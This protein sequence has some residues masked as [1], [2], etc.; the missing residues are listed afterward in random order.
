MLLGLAYRLERGC[1]PPNQICG[2]VE[3]ETS[4]R[5]ALSIRE[6]SGSHV[7]STCNQ[8]TLEHQRANSGLRSRELTDDIVHHGDL[9]L[10]IF[11]AVAVA[12]VDHQDFG[13]S[14]AI[15]QTERVPHGA[16]PEVGS[17]FSPASQHQVGV[18]IS[19]SFQN[20]GPPFLRQ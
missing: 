9:P 12:A 15:E 11:F 3:S 13:E 7:L 10:R 2:V 14:R 8:V 5:D 6:W 18:G 17:R 20:R 19:S 1:Q 16:R 4:I